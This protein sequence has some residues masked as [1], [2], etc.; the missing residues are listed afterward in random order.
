MRVIS[1]AVLVLEPLAVPLALAAATR[2]CDS[3][4]AEKRR[5]RTASTVSRNARAHFGEKRRVS[6]ST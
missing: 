5:L 2:A 6:G 1:A 3:R 4:D